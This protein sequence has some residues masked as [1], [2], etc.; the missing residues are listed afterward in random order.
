MV[1]NLGSVGCY[2]F[3]KHKM[4]RYCITSVSVN[5]TSI[6]LKSIT[7]I[8]GAAADAVCRRPSPRQ[9]GEEDGRRGPRRV[10]G[11]PPREV[12]RDWVGGERAGAS[13]GDV[14]FKQC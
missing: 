12:A 6:V 13:P 9:P 5:K 8:T 10:A 4:S 11:Q 14:G 1:A 3:V 2:N 7:I